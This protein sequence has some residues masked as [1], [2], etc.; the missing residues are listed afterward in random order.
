VHDA[1]PAVLGLELRGTLLF[2]TD[3]SSGQYVG[4]G[5]PTRE[6]AVKAAISQ[7]AALRRL[8]LSSYL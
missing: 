3:H 1:T 5:H 2:S 4:I 7:Q 6:A 8:A